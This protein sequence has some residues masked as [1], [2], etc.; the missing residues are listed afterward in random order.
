MDERLPHCRLA[1]RTSRAVLEGAMTSDE[2]DTGESMEMQ[3]KDGALSQ[4]SAQVVYR[5]QKCPQAR[6]GEQR[7]E[8]GDPMNGESVNVN[9]GEARACGDGSGGRKP[10]P[11]RGVKG[12][13]WN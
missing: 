12:K 11:G 9:R 8:D 6:L 5:K 13:E 3:E 10:S 2:R 1:E 7:E 4:K